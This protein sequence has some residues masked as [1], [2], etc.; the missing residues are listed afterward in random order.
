MPPDHKSLRANYQV[1]HFFSPC[2]LP[3]VR[4]IH[5]RSPCYFYYFWFVLVFFIR[6]ASVYFSPHFHSI[7]QILCSSFVIAAPDFGPLPVFVA[8]AAVLIHQLIHN[9]AS[10]PLA[11]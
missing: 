5:F 1:L 2:I 3:Y 11:R 8:A 6:F 7:R 9:I 4:S 10:L